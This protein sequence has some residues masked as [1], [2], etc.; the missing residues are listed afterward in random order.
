MEPHATYTNLRRFLLKWHNLKAA[1]KK[2][3]IPRSLAGKLVFLHFE[4]LKL[5]SAN[6]PANIDVVVCEIR[7]CYKE[8]SSTSIGEIKKRLE[9]LHNIS[10][11]ETHLKKLREKLGLFKFPTKYCQ[12]IRDENKIKRLEFAT[13][14]LEHNEL[15]ED[16]V[17]TDE[18]IVER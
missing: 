12:M 4:A 14:M 9:T 17:F 15:F 1:N 2:S 11:S 5:Y 6:I 10:V 18:S 7:R 3:Y 8:N 16:C 13:R